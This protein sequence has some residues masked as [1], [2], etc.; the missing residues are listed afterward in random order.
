MP[1]I[2]A[3]PDSWTIEPRPSGFVARIAEVWRYRRMFQF[4]GARA[5]R[6]LYQRTVL[7]AAWIFLRPLVPLFIR[8]FVFGGLL[9]VGSGS[10]RVPYFLFLLVGGAAWD[11]FA[12]AA[13]W[14][15]RSLELNGGILS[16]LYVPRL[17]LPISSM[18]PALVNFAITL[19]VLIGAFI[20]YR[21]Q[22]GVWYLDTTWLIVAPLSLV[23]MLVVALGIAL[24]TSVLVTQA[25]DV[26]F[27]LGYV[28]DF[29]IYLTPVM[30][31]LTIV[32]DS[33]QW[34]M[35]LNPMAVLVVAFRGAILGGEG[36]TPVEWLTALGIVVA[37]L[38][39][40]LVYF[41][42][43]EAEAVDNL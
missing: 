7:G 26:R 35:M 38:S 18:V 6:K 9:N 1:D 28:L 31:P 11:L 36:P 16:R 32:P 2:A 17:I 15:T 23:L 29:W 12:G 13:M 40:G 37:V 14:A 22:R 25:R 4:F 20:Y 33:V 8:L 41:H 21:V 3:S 30:Y 24:F 27:G 10:S 19:A 43:A 5:L 34:V 39:A 42:K